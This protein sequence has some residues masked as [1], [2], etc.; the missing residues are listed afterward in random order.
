MTLMTMVGALNRALDDALRT[1]D[2]VVL[3]GQDIG[4]DEGVF[5]VTADLLKRY[6]E[7]R[8][9]DTPLAEGAIIVS[10]LRMHVDSDP[11]RGLLGA[12]AFEVVW[13]LLPLTLLALMVFFSYDA[14]QADRQGEAGASFVRIEV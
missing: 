13:T 1:D 14:F 7:D 4:Q 9:I 8:V 10:A 6:G 12:R 11:A 2:D 5:R 3:L